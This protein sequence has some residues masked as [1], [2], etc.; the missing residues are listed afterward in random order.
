MDD[1]GR[2]FP[3]EEER[4][5]HSPSSGLFFEV[6]RRLFSGMSSFQRIEVFENETFGNIL[7]LDGLVQTSE[8]DEYFYHEMIVHPAFLSHPSPRDCLIIGGGDGGTLRETLRHPI[9]SA[10]LVEIDQ[11]VI[12][13]CQKHFP[14]LGTA[15]KDERTEMVI[16]DGNT[17]IENTDKT[18]DVIIIDS[19]EPLGPS[20]VLH[21]EEFYRKVI[22]RMNPEGIVAAQV[23]S[24]FFHVEHL[25]KMSVMLN[26]LFPVVCFYCGPVPTY[27]G[28]T[29][30][31]VFLSQQRH[32]TEI[33]PVAVGGLKYYTPQIHEAAFVLPGFLTDI[34][35]Q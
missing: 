21:S 33:R 18:Y 34:L 3:F 13:V 1:T 29:W 4:E 26:T 31:Y 6:K 9:E 16:T 14:W 2:K 5:Y 10:V 24:P 27:P 7:L 32:P 35:N 19:S 8:R 22:K 17:Y 12:E 30:T 20:S 25:K 11:L 23:G 15:L 28:G